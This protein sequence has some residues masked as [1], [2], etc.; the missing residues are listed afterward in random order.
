MTAPSGGMRPRRRAPRPVA[1]PERLRLAALRWVLPGVLGGI[2]PDLWARLRDRHAVDPR[3]RVRALTV[4]LAA[5]E[6][7]RLAAAEEDAFGDAIAGTDVVAP[8][9]VLGHDRSGTTLLHHLLAQDPAV[10]APT[11]LETLHPWTF[12]TAADRHRRRLGAVLPATRVFDAV[13]AHPDMPN[14][15]EF[16]LAAMTGTSPL[17][18]YA[19][20]QAWATYERH[21]TLEDVPTP[22]AEAWAHALVTFA[23][24]LTH[25]HGQR[26]VLK[27]PPHTARLPH[28]LR[29]FPDARFV[30]LHRHPLAVY[31]SVLRMASTAMPAAQLQ[32]SDGLDLGAALVASYR[33]MLQRYLATRSLAPPGRLVEVA[34]A[35]LVRDPAGT[36]RSV[37]EALGLP[38]WDAAR[39]LV[40]RHA[41][42]QAGFLVGPR[43][44]LPAAL[45]REIGRAW[46]FAL[47]AWGYA[48]REPADAGSA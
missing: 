14:E 25:A 28:L 40:E 36:V 27:S 17:L 45:R 24:T 37:Y 30:F 48:D 18:R 43:P 16:A 22:E 47:D 2:R 5:R 10:H 7:E 44:P 15:D 11:L 42:A 38:G 32:R 6:T 21:L 34:Y 31:P 35:D 39:P 41:R 4:A 12:R 9:F 3:Y 19:F 29:L 23:R 13:R 1:L 8:L 33:T 26:L 20:P 46:G